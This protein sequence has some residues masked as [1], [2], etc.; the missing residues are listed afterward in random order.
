[1]PGAHAV[2]VRGHPVY[3]I[4]VQTFTAD[5]VGAIQR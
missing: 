3:S 1:V 5:D 4:V 2:A